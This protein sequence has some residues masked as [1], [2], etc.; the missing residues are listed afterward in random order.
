MSN[1]RDMIIHSVVYS[2]R[3]SQYFP[4]PYID[5]WDNINVELDL[6]TDAA[7]ADMKGVTDIDMHVFK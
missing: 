7:Q 4:Q 6:S 5:S 3:M 1:G 2:I